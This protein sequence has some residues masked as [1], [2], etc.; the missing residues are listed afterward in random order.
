M[1]KLDAK[2]HKHV[3]YSHGLNFN[4]VAGRTMSKAGDY[5]LYI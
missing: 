2:D 5:I 1:L 4:Q 3:L